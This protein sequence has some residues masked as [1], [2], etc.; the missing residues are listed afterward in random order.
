MTL[1]NVESELSSVLGDI[2][3]AAM[4]VSRWGVVT[5]RLA[6]MFGGSAV[7]F[8]QDSRSPTSVVFDTAGFD[9]GFIDSYVHTYA[10]LNAWTVGVAAQPP[11]SLIAG[12]QLIGQIEFE[13]TEWYNGWL[14]PQGLYHGT[15]AVLANERGLVTQFSVIRPKHAGPM[16][17]TDL[18][19]FRVL[20]P[21]LQ[22]G[23]KVHHEL[24]AARGGIAAAMAGFERLQ[25]AVFL[26]DGTSRIRFAN[27]AA[28]RLLGEADVLESRAGVLTALKKATDER[29][30]AATG[31]ASATAGTSI[32]ACGGVVP[33]PRRSGR[34]LVALVIPLRTGIIASPKTSAVALVLIRDPDLPPAV[35]TGILRA[36]LGLTPAEANTVAQIASGATLSEIAVANNIGIE[37]V[38]SH[39]K[40][41]MAKAEVARQ[42]DLVSLA[43]RT[44][45]FS[46][47]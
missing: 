12:H 40:R 34:P 22:R 18:A 33:L 21:H 24:S 31:G 46:S 29:L 10:G 41:S 4:D 15:A 13:R 45:G 9:D 28:E 11:G 25:A 19:K 30:Q 43:L 8:A 2:Y 44:A 37:T 35:D 14:R 3:D 6:D 17:E 26:V 36:T 1:L 47:S 27:R 39:V 5:R 42:A 7:L 38:R 32:G 16:S 20:V 23:I